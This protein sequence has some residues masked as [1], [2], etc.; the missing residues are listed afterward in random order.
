MRSWLLMLGGLLVWA[1]HFFV[2]YGV[3]SIFPGQD[4]ARWLTIAATALAL[5][6]DGWIVR[7]ALARR[8]KDDFAARVGMLAA[9]L[10]AVAI[11]WQAL[12][13]IV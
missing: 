4:M 7:R 9:L 2:A 11:L 12:P 13:A 1:A 6:V 10:S 5:V 3:A 8:D